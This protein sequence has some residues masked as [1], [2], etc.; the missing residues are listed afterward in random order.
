MNI[1]SRR[2]LGSRNKDTYRPNSLSIS[3]L[4]ICQACVTSEFVELGV[5]A[6][7]KNLPVNRQIC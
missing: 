6:L 3:I 5:E 7:S 2:F 1:N 4:Q